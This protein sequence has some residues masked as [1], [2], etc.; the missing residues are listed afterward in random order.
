MKQQSLFIEKQRNQFG[1][2][3]LVGCRKERRPLSSKLPIHL[4]LKATDSVLLLR[5]KKQVEQILRTYSKKLGV[6]IYSLAVQ[7]DHIHL[8]VRAMNRS[9]Y[10]RWIRA[11]T[12]VLA[13]RLT[14]LK[15]KLRPFTRIASWGRDFIRLKNYILGNWREGNFIADAHARVDQFLEKNVGPFF[16]KPGGGQAP[17]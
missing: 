6:K 16:T 4:V 10:V 9:V 7:Y 17:P 3:L 8:A 15:W 11:V 1:G 12:S 5:N 2:S 14:G 13:Q